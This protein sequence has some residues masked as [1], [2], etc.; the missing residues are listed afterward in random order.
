MH[1]GPEALA[2]A[3]G[4]GIKTPAPWAS[5]WS[6][7]P[8]GCLCVHSSL[9]VLLGLGPGSSPFWHWSSVLWAYLVDVIPYP[10]LG[11]C[12][13]GPC[14]CSPPC[15]PEDPFW[16]ISPLCLIALT[17]RPCATVTLC[18]AVW[19]VVLASTSAL[20]GTPKYPKVPS[21]LQGPLGPHRKDLLMK[22]KR[23]SVRALSST[24]DLLAGA[25]AASPRPSG[26][27]HPVKLQSP[28]ERGASCLPQQM[29]G[30]AAGERKP[31]ILTELSRLEAKVG[32][33]SHHRFL[34]PD[35]RYTLASMQVKR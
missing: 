17:P 10:A 18:C 23:E 34:W 13:E 22:G 3:L 6:S 12:L 2:P 8:A 16:S 28:R 33:V 1:K 9:N 32:C 11:V 27:L 35:P 20:G 19:F 31:L 4:T 15:G 26:P 30:R 25:A 5:F 7:C 21:T 29:A 24:A 14:R